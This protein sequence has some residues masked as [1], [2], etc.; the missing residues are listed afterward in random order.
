AS[1]GEARFPNKILSEFGYLSFLVCHPE[2]RAIY[3]LAEPRRQRVA[4]FRVEDGEVTWSI[5]VFQP[6]NPPGDRFDNLKG[7]SRRIDEQ[8]AES[9]LDAELLSQWRVREG[10]ERTFCGNYRLAR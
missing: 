6:F 10:I 2:R 7:T 1:G 3:E 9:L 8:H 4:G 5:R